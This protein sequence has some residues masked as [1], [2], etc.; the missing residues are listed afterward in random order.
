MTVILIFDAY[1]RNSRKDI[2]FYTTYTG[3]VLPLVH[4]SSDSTLM[5]SLSH[6]LTVCH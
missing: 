1:D 4:I 3:M 5:P 2:V 6:L